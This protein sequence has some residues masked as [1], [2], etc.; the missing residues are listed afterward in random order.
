[1]YQQRK[2][3]LEFT[4]PLLVWALGSKMDM[5]K[6]THRQSLAIGW[7]KVAAVSTQRSSISIKQKWRRPLRIQVSLGMMF[8]SLQRFLDVELLRRVLIETSKISTQAT[9]TCSLSTAQL[10]FHVQQL[11]RCSRIT[12]KMAS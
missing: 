12:L 4:C 1:M 10:A 7:A 9:S 6:R 2:S 3:H 11:G 8:S 5:E